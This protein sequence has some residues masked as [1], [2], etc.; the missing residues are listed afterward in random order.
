M[1][2]NI[3]IDIVPINILA[4]VCCMHCISLDDSLY[5]SRTVYPRHTSGIVRIARKIQPQIQVVPL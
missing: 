5:F 2:T 1:V 3:H 4:K